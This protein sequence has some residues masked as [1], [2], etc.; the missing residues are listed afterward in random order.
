MFWCIVKLNFFGNASCLVWRRTYSVK[1][2][3]STKKQKATQASNSNSEQTRK[4]KPNSKS[5]SNGKDFTPVQV[6]PIPLF[7]AVRES[8]EITDR[9]QDRNWND[10][11][12]QMEI[13]RKRMILDERDKRNSILEYLKNYA[14]K[15]V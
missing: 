13:Q 3:K 11:E 15:A 6:P 10:K 4:A 1:S 12:Y 5:R 2:E 9:I 14:G 7:L 8:E